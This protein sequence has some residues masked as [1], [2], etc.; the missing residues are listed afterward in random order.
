MKRDEGQQ[1]VEWS[2]H[3]PRSPDLEVALDIRGDVDGFYVG[4]LNGE[5]VASY[6]EAQVADDVR[7]IAYLYV[8]KRY[9]M[10]G[11]ARRMITTARDIRQ[12]RYWTGVVGFDAVEYAQSMYEKFDG[13]PAFKMSYYQGTVSADVAQ[14]RS[15]TDIRLVNNYSSYYRS[16]S[17]THFILRVLF[18]DILTYLGF[19]ARLI[20]SL[21]EKL[22]IFSSG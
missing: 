4:E 10:M 11:L 1:V 5:M 17:V 6:V 7:F 12:C 22:S 9:R 18:P 14:D 20:R 16:V 15:G 13:K 8:V 19:A 21:P 2:R 3:I